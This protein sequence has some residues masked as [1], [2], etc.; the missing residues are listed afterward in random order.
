MNSLEFMDEFLEAGNHQPGP[1]PV[2]V[3]V[4]G[5]LVD[6]VRVTFQSSEDPD[7]EPVIVIH[8]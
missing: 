2:K 1:N 3:W 4:D 6:I 8:C 7:T 5:E